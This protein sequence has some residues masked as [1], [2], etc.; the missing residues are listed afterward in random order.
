MVDKNK[1]IKSKSFGKWK[2][3]KDGEIVLEVKKQDVVDLIKDLKS[4][5]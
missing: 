5:N 4:R 2:K 1:T 3:R